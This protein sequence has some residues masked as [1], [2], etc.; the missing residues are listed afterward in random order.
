MSRT[1]AATMPKQRYLRQGVSG[2]PDGPKESSL[3]S[4]NTMRELEQKGKWPSEDE[5][6]TVTAPFKEINFVS[7]DE[8]HGNDAQGIYNR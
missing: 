1:T 4:Q 2:R 3:S 8:P 7:E 6:D 5:F